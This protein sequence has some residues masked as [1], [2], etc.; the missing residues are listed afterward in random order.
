MGLKLNKY[1]PF[2][3]LYFFVNSAGLPFGLLYTSLLAPFFYIWV[4]IKRK[5]EP[6]LPF[7]AVFLP[8]FI[9]HLFFVGVDEKQ[10]AI[11]LLNLLAVYIFGQAFYTWLKTDHNKEKILTTLL[12][13]N[14]VLCLIAI[15]FYFTP[16]YS[17]FWI[18]QTITD[19]VGGFLRLKML[20][21]EASYYALLF[22]PLFLYFFLQYV[23]QKN[24]MNKYR[25]LF[26]LFLPFILSFSLGVITSL[27]IAGC[28][29]L[30]IHFRTLHAKRRVVNGFI[31]TGF[32]G[33]VLFLLI[34]LFFRDNPFFTRLE[35]IISGND[36]SA[37]GRTG[38]AFIIARNLL[39][40]GNSWWGI[41]PGQLKLEGA[42][43]IRGYYLYFHTTPVAIP[44]AA[45]ETLALFGWVG[46]IGRI[47]IEIFFFIITKTWK[48]Y[49][50]L[51]LFLFIFIY[52]FTGSFIT[53][54]AEYVIWILAFTNA[55]PVFDVPGRKEI[56][57]ALQS[58]PE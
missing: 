35:N 22:V 25:L 36:S 45:A 2:A 13:I 52:Q 54:A 55:F 34:Y 19:G 7:I 14:T 33:V 4:L 1:L 41:G 10:Y 29:C 50:R 37:S 8:F 11:S 26:M 39:E 9:A 21:Y 43:L 5:N 16:F 30:F 27:L 56:K 48:N 17:W 6:A 51:M 47:A 44:N 31:N 20:T 24:S 18:K 58:V 3:F 49:Y 53:N 57:P 28:I 46:F 40:Q 15:V 38:D 32:A 42:D 23:L 12:I